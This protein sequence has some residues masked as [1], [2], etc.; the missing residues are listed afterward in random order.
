MM[1][2]ILYYKTI[3]AYWTV[4]L[5][6]P[7]SYICNTNSVSCLRL[8]SVFFEGSF[9]NSL[10]CLCLIHACSTIS[11]PCLAELVVPVLYSPSSPVHAFCCG[12]FL[13]ASAYLHQ[14]FFLFF[15]LPPSSFVLKNNG[16]DLNVGIPQNRPDK[17]DPIALRQFVPPI[18]FGSC[19]DLLVL[20]LQPFWSE[21]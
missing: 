6:P 3:L 16:F 13:A 7:K 21:V 19:K 14:L 1:G 2:G 20:L 10:C 15:F 4:S 5:L 9:C 12:L 8:L 11:S 17:F 18:R